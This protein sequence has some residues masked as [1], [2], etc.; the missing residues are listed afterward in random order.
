MDGYKNN[1]NMKPRQH[2]NRGILQHR[3]VRRTHRADDSAAYDY[4]S[5]KPSDSAADRDDNSSSDA[6]RYRASDRS[7]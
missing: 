2:R 3:P 4:R 6:N 5:D 7:L 1:N